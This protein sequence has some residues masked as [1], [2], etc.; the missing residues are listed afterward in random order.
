[1]RKIEATHVFFDL[2]GTLTDPREGIVRCLAYALGKVGA[3]ARGDDDLAKM[4][5]L[6]L[7]P[8][9]T[10]LLSTNDPSLIEQ[11]VGFYRERFSS[12]GV[13]ENIIYPEIPAALAALRALGLSLLV[14]TSKAQVFAERFASMLALTPFLT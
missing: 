12:S 4:I 9:F 10:K 5:G 1:M 7:R 6:P 3:A 14:V 2:D 11:A 13:Y 8:S